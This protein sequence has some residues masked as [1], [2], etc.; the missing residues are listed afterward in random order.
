M[1]IDHLHGL[2]EMPENIG[3]VRRLWVITLL[4]EPPAASTTST[5]VCSAAANFW[6]NGID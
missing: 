6:S 5:Y 4:G 3:P 1:V 2:H